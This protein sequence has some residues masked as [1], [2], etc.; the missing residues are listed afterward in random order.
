MKRTF[1][2]ILFSTLVLFFQHTVY[3]QTIPDPPSLSSPSDGTQLT[4]TDVT[5]QWSAVSNAT[6][7]EIQISSDPLFNDVIEDYTTGGSTSFVWTFDAGGTYYWRV[8]SINDAGESDFS[9]S[10]SLVIA[11]DPEINFYSA[12]VPAGYGGEVTIDGNYFG[13]NPGT[14]SFYCGDPSVSSSG[15][16]PSGYVP[17]N[18]I[19]SWSPNKIDCY[20]PLHASS[21]PIIITTSANVSNDPSV[22]ESYDVTWG[23]L[24]GTWSIGISANIAGWRN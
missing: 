16:T 8:A 2:V 19:V 5:F 24:G 13:D 6:D 1:Y 9:S 7:Y 20:V 11:V 15:S 10:W 17:S 23:Y 4:T 21:G 22:T 14:V 3:S 12:P 18:D